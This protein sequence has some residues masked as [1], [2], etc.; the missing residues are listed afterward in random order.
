[1]VEGSMHGAWFLLP[2]ASPSSWITPSR[3]Y[4]LTM[5]SHGRLDASVSLRLPGSTD[6]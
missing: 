5:P 4:T 6:S 2:R 1:M 3:T